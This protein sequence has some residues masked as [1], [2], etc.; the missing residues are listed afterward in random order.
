M[1][2]LNANMLLHLKYKPFNYQYIYLHIKLYVQ[3][4]IFYFHS[5]MLFLHMSTLSTKVKF[6]GLTYLRERRK[7]HKIN[8]IEVVR[9][10]Q[11][12][13][14]VQRLGRKHCNMGLF[15]LAEADQC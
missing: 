3:K 5:L 4:F 11:D 15:T 8:F 2:L 14:S 7:I 13:L 9:L 1:K 10:P 6:Y 12:L